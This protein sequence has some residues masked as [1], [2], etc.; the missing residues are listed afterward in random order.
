MDLISAVQLRPL[1]TSARLSADEHGAKPLRFNGR[2]PANEVGISTGEVFFATTVSSLDDVRDFKA[3]R[4][5]IL[6][7]RRG[8]WRKYQKRQ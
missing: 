5:A 7:G 2:L 1:F 8:S 4:F 6:Y 3:E